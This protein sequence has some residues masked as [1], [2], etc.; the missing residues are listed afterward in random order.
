[1][2]TKN[3]ART[4]IE[5]GRSRWNK[6]QRRYSNR[7]ARRRVREYARSLR[8]DPDEGEGSSAPVREPVWRCHNDRLSAAERW[9]ASFAGRPWAEARAEMARRFDTRTIAG[10]HIVYDH[11]LPSVKGS[12][13]ESFWRHDFEVDEEGILRPVPQRRYRRN[14]LPPGK[15]WRSPAAIARWAQGRKLALR[16]TRWFW[17]EPTD[18]TLVE[19]FRQGAP[20]CDEDLAFFQTLTEEAQKLL[21]FSLA[22]ES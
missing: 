12:G 14:A 21:V 2:A 15:Q 4:V 6:A 9:L 17:F 22:R 13:R 10:Q 11:L 8:Y 16:G 19:S 3:L 7:R 1:M 5:G 20:V 18:A